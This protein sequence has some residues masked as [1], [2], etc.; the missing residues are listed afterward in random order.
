MWQMVAGAVGAGR[1]IATLPQFL[2]TLAHECYILAYQFYSSRQLCPQP[3]H[4]R[5]RR[6]IAIRSRFSRPAVPQPVVNLG[7][8]GDHRAVKMVTRPVYRESK[9]PLPSLHCPYTT[10]SVVRDLRPTIQ[11]R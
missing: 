8:Y 11:N 7:R 1:Q 4:L 10:A 3:S 6:K 2:N 9:F 5:S